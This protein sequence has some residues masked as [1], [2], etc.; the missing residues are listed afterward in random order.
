MIRGVIGNDRH[1]KTAMNEIAEE[2][3]ILEGAGTD[4][5]G[6]ALEAATFY[7]LTD[8]EAA[9]VSETLRMSSPASSR[10][11]RVNEKA[12]TSYKGWKIPAGVSDF[13]AL[14]RMIV[15]GS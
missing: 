8:P 13:V 12:S 1:S 14:G 5:T 15:E 11:P 4:S 7:I 6:Q 3:L 9:V 2:A 10:S